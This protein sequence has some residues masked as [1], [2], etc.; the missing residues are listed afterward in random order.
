MAER[1]G[2]Q[3]P[4]QSVVLPY[5]ET[6]GQEAIDLYNSTSNEA[7]EWQQLQIYD[8]LAHDEAGKWVHT[9]Y[10]YEVSRRNGK[11]E[12]VIIRCLYGLAKGEQMLYTAH[13]TDTA[14]AIWERL[15]DLT[16]AAGIKVT[17]EYRALGREHLFVETGG[18][19]EF[20]TRTS[21]SGLGTGYDTVII[22]EAQEY[23][24][25]Q[26][27]ALKYVVSS[28]RN[29]QTIFC[30]TPPTVTSSGTVFTKMREEVL[31]GKRKRAGWAEW[32]VDYQVDPNNKEYWYETNPSLGYIL[33]EES[34]EDEITG[35][36]LDFNIQRL[37][38]WV[39]YNQKSVITEKDWGALKVAKMPGL[40][41][42]LYAGVKYGVDGKNVALAIA[43]KTTDKRFFVEGIDCVPAK[44]GNK[45]LLDF[46]TKADVNEVVV[47]G[48]SGQN[49]LRD[50]LKDAHFR[51][52]VILPKVA[53]YITAN[54]SF[55]QAVHE[56]II[57]HNDQPS[58]TQVATNCEHRRIGTNGG[59]GFRALREGMD[60]ALLDSVILAYWRA[61]SSR[62]RR[63]QKVRT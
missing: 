1:Y 46:L 50:E 28:S 15:V 5:S 55:E 51:K 27:S 42:K 54:A 14:H 63:T 30:G 21:K 57:C 53:E 60:I 47:D 34:V 11:S 10:G 37:G 20:R 6:K 3:T 58:L 39:Q 49:L 12:I 18:K 41:G 45:W 48:A 26:E 31:A 23:T 44:A 61:S 17:G 33:S 25:D 13:R 7:I 36:D 59:Y 56:K 22:D 9:R 19:I 2:R 38:Y 29:P 24:I 43:V 40:S 52:K 4:T 8:I 35:D 16:K 32:S 62:D